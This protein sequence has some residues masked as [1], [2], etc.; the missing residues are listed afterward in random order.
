MESQKKSKVA[1]AIALGAGSMVVVTPTIQ[2]ALA[3]AS[4][5]QRKLQIISDAADQ[6]RLVIES[7]KPF[8]VAGPVE[9]PFGDGG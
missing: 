3:D 8:R 2:T 4:S 5:V 1:A 6:G 7:Q 9:K